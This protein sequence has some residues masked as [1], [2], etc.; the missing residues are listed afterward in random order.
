M[1][2][3]LNLT[4]TPADLLI[5]AC[6]SN[7][8]GKAAPYYGELVRR[9]GGESDPYAMEWADTLITMERERRNNDIARQQAEEVQAAVK[10]ALAEAMGY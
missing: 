8:P 7:P 4:N 2:T 5:H 3:E 9:G 1:N 10:K 6:L